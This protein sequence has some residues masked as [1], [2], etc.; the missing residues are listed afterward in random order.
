MNILTLIF[1]SQTNIQIVFLRLPMYYDLDT[2]KVINQ[3][4]KFKI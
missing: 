1:M 3:L 4:L 2:E